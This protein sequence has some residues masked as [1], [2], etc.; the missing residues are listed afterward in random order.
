MDFFKVKVSSG[1]LYITQNLNLLKKY[2]TLSGI[3]HQTNRQRLKSRKKF[4]VALLA[5]MKHFS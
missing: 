2:V 3:L 1:S 5:E 4:H